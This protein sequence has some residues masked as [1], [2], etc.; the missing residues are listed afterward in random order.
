[1][2]GWFLQE[3][4]QGQARSLLKDCVLDMGGMIE[5]MGVQRQ[6]IGCYRFRYN[7]YTQ[8]NR[9]WA[10]TVITISYRRRLG[11][12]RILRYN[13]N[14]ESFRVRMEGLWRI[15]DAYREL[16]EY[17]QAWKDLQEAEVDLTEEFLEDF[18]Q[19]RERLE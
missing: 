6:I 3:L 14:P 19:P 7:A 5:E 12:K 17:Y 8:E 1:M 11:W 18:G 15:A 4:P 2:S 10:Q 13:A 16:T 9:V